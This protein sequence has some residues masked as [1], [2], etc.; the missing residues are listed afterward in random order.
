VLASR[1]GIT[2]RAALAQQ[3]AQFVDDRKHLVVPV[4]A[5]AVVRFLLALDDPA[6]LAEDP[7]GEPH[8]QRPCEI[9]RERNA[10]L[11]DRQQPERAI[12]ALLGIERHVDDP[13]V[14]HERAFA[15]TDLQ[16]LIRV[17]GAHRHH[18][19]VGLIAGLLLEPNT[20][21]SPTGCL[22]SIRANV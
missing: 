18:A 16:R 19:L 1:I 8:E 7:F 20:S 14:H 2:V 22:P 6:I 12:G 4:G 21:A 5:L 3:V 9:E 11:V 10:R 17:A 15:R 13:Q